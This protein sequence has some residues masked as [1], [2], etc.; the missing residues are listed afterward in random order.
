MGLF[1]HILSWTRS[2]VLE[3]QSGFVFFFV[4]TPK[5]YI[6]VSLNEKL[7]FIVDELENVYM[8]ERKI[9]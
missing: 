4:R 3:D 1:L 2:F 7:K 6:D 5:L 9:I 8:F